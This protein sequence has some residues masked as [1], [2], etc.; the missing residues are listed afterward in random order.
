[1]IWH[2]GVAFDVNQ[3]P[4]PLYRF[5]P[6][7]FSGACKTREFRAGEFPFVV[8]RDIFHRLGGFSLAFQNRFEDI[9]FC[10]RA[11]EMGFKTVYTPRSVILRSGRSW[12]ADGEADRINRIRFYS[13]WAGSLWQ[14]DREYLQE[15]GISHDQL[16]ALYREWAQRVAHGLTQPGIF[17]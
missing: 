2:I 14:D 13:K 17:S 12:P 11:E 9:D 3:S 4:F 16:S 5:L 15:D 8:S 10:L 7:E 1:M 6:P